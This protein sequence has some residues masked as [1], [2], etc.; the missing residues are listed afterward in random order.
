METVR[1]ASA[2]PPSEGLA[3]ALATIGT[4]AAVRLGSRVLITVCTFTTTA[5]VVRAT[6]VQRF[7]ALAFGLSIVGLIAGL[8]TGLATASNR[9]I[10]SAVAKGERPLDAIRALSAVV[11]AVAGLGAAVIIVTLGLTQHQLDGAEVWVVGVAMSVLLLGRVSAAAGSSVAR[12]VGRLSLMEVPPT[13]EVV[14]K[15]V[16]VIA[17]LVVG[18]WQGWV[19]LAAVYGGAG[20]AATVAAVIVVR[21]ALGTLAVMSPAARAGRDLVVLTAPFVLGAI[22]YRLIRGFDVMVLGVIQPG[23]TVGAYAP[24]LAMVEGLVM[25][26]PGLLGA[27]FVTEATGLHESG[28]R[29]GFG[30]LYLAV[31][32]VSV[33][34]AM[35]AFTLLAVAPSEV[36]H[37]VYGA[38]FPASPTVVW[39]LIAGYFVTVALG[40]NGQALVAAGA[41]STVGKALVLPAVTM[42][43]TALVLIPLQGA[44]GAAVASTTSF[45]VLNASL[46]RALH[47]T[48][49]V[50]PLRPRRI[51]LLGSATISI[52]LAAS[53]RHL[54][55]GGFWAAAACSFVGW[56]AWLAVIVS[57][58]LMRVDELKAL[59]PRMLRRAR[60]GGVR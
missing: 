52:A 13:V 54:V 33:I 23:A 19:P 14:G 21:Q 27:M 26:V 9:S 48:T 7:G 32:K 22:A 51:L 10:A 35:P 50:H 25:L 43:A 42:V 2:H 34:L 18:G 57:T 56:G 3:G 29:R 40:F 38:R 16:L 4:G 47:R 41:W 12:G 15:L 31:S 11:V 1:D 30:D 37:A 60:E 5:L 8:F 59:R 58:R 24:T 44:V 55:G 36:L 6:G 20:I 17:L 45:V 49:G 46:S 53:L 28:D 39:I